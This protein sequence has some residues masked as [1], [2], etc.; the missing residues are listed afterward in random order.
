MLTPKDTLTGG[1]ASPLGN[2]IMDPLMA[3]LSLSAA[4]QP[5]A[6]VVSGMK[7]ANWLVD[8]S[9]RLIVRAQAGQHRMGGIAQRLFTAKLPIL[10]AKF[11]ESIYLQHHDAAWLAIEMS[12]FK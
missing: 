7:T 4:T 10:V 12:R 9:P 3:P 5:S 8:I 2:T 11:I 6:S 1:N